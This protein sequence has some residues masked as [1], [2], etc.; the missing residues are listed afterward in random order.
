MLTGINVGRYNDAAAGVANLPAL[1]K[2]LATTDIKRIRVSSIEPIH[3]DD[4]LVQ[5]LATEPKLCEHLHIPLQSGSDAVLEAMNRHYSSEQFIA[6]VDRLKQVAPHIAVTTDVIVGFPGETEADFNKTLEVCD[7][8]G[9]AKIHVFRYSKRAGTPAA[10]R[11]Q[12]DARTSARRAQL[13]RVLGARLAEDYRK[14]AQGRTLEVL[15]ESARDG[16]LNAT[17]REHIVMSFDEG[18]TDLHGASMKVGNIY[19]VIG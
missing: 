1:I 8:C 14:N 17:S 18:A 16:R 10:Q 9:F 2:R 3:V 5:L 12:V 7:R 6:M 11:E 19:S 4:E 15:V 13:I